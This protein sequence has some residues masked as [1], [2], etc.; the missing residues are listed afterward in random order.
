MKPNISSEKLDSGVVGNMKKKKNEKEIPNS[1]N[2]QER[3]L[4]QRKYV[5]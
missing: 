4:P 2:S 5:N 3:G 1:L